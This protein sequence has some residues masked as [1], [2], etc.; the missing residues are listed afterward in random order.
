[1]IS[2]FFDL[3]EKRTN[4]LNLN[5]AYNIDRFLFK[6]FMSKIFVEDVLNILLLSKININIISGKVSIKLILIYN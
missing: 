2:L 5:K 1:M 4:N 3:R 6:F